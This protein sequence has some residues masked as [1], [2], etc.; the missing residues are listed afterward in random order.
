MSEMITLTGY[1]QITLSIWSLSQLHV[2]LSQ[3]EKEMRLI[4]ECCVSS[5]CMPPVSMAKIHDS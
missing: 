3:L 1:E 2:C 4:S 5:H